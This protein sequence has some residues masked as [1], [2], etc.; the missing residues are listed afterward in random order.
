M[1]MHPAIAYGIVSTDEEAD[2]ID[3]FAARAGV[4]ASDLIAAIGR[5]SS[6]D[7][8][9]IGV[10]VRAP[11]VPQPDPDH[12]LVAR[13]F[14]RYGNEETAH[15]TAVAMER[16]RQGWTRDGAR[17]DFHRQVMEALDSR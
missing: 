4:S 7:L 12:D 13:L 15:R 5:K 14:R 3:R 2:E 10:H 17:A 11:P 9:S 16:R 8:D 6:A 1:S